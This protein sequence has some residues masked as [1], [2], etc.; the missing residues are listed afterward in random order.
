MS[1]S[2]K[3]RKYVSI[4]QA[5]KHLGINLDDL[6]EWLYESKVQLYAHSEY[7][8]D[9]RPIAPPDSKKL[10]ATNRTLKKIH[11]LYIKEI[12]K[13]R[14]QAPAYDRQ[15][16]SVGDLKMSVKDLIKH[17]TDLRGLYNVTDSDIEQKN[18]SKREN[19]E[20][21]DRGHHHKKIRILIAAEA[22]KVLQEKRSAFSKKN[23]IVHIERLAEHLEDTKETWCPARKTEYGFSLA[24]IKNAIR[25]HFQENP[26]LLR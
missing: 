3:G 5:A 23:G 21:N 18:R 24:S 15:K 9:V 20:V 7:T 11:F 6:T 26:N 19:V 17:R 13:F 16:I 2:L 22:V 14:L 4:E 1:N 10:L 8:E 12:R 25:L